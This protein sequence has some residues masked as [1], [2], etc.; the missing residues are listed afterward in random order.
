MLMPSQLEPPGKGQRCLACYSAVGLHTLQPGKVSGVHMPVCYPQHPTF[1]S[2]AE[3]EVWQ[4]L[5]AGLP[6]RA[7]IIANWERAERVEEY[8]SD[9][10]VVWPG[11]GIFVIEVKGGLVSEDASGQWWSTDG[12]GQR[13]AIDPIHQAR[14]NSHAIEDYIERVW[15]QGKLHLQWLVCFPYTDLPTGFQTAA[16]ARDRIVDRSDLPAL[17]DRLQSLGRE[18][19]GR[20]VSAERCETFVEHMVDVR[21]PQNELLHTQYDRERLVQRLTEEQFEILEEMELNDRF[22]IV[23]PAGSGKTYLALEQ[24]R[25]RVLRGERVA[26]VCYSYGLHRYLESVVATWPEEQRPA[27]IGTFHALAR[28]WGAY[29]PKDADSEWWLHEAPLRMLAGAA[30]LSADKRFDTLIVDEGQDFLASW[31]NALTAGL[32]NPEAGGLFVFGDMDQDIFARGE[33]KQ[34]GVALRRVTKNMRNARPIAELA[35]KLSRTPT[36][37][38]GLDGPAVRFE[39]CTRETAI[40]V[41]EDIAEGLFLDP[42]PARDI[43][44]LTTHHKSGPHRHLLSQGKEAYWDAFWSDDDIFYAT[45]T[46]FKGLERP[47]VVVAIDG[48]VDEAH[49]RES[50]YVA[51]SRARDQLIICGSVDDIRL[52]G[53]DELVAALCR[54]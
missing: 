25:R 13:H 53:G 8:E 31:W 48:W 20:E 3:R 33:F 27:Y 17:A 44:L 45:V 51:M 26:M 9:L 52:A 10:I 38:L 46:G 21:D 23:G 36:R 50:L 37:H 15:S 12:A 47:V 6:A 39:E 49:A 42:W 14:R 1:A 7:T 4:R 5:V 16:A 19:A 41:A 54:G 24:A 18:L 35:G 11:Q 32:H 28:E 2:E 40:D 34:L 43:V 22:A 29:A 30:K